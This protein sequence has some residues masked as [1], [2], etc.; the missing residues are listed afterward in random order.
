MKKR[1]LTLIIIVFAITLALMFLPIVSA[2]IFFSELNSKY[3]LGDVVEL[4]VK[5]DPIIKDRLLKIILF[6]NGVDIIEFNNLPDEQGNVNV[7]LP[8]NY[9]TIRDANGNCFFFGDYAGESRK[10]IEFEIS[11]LLIVKLATE[12][13]FANPEDEIVVSG[14]AEKLNGVSVD[15]EVEITIPLLNLLEVSEVEI[16]EETTTNATTNQSSENQSTQSSE[17]NSQT[18][19]TQT[20]Q[21]QTEQT[22]PTQFSTGKF[23][24]K[25]IDKQFSLTLKIPEN[26]PA[27][28]YRIDVLVYEQIDSYRTSEGVAIASLKV[29]QVLKNIE[30]ALNDF[31]FDPGTSIDIK[32]TLL[33]QTG[34]S[35]GGEI[36]VIIKDE[37]QKYF[38]KIGRSQENIQ[39][40][41]PTNLSSGY[42]NLIASSSGG[43]VN[44]TK[45]IFVNEK[46]IASFNLAN[47]TLIVKNIGNIPYRKDIQVELNAKSFIKRVS[48]E[49]G[50]SAKFKLTGADELYNV[51]ISDG[52]SELTMDSVRLT[53]RVINVAAV[54][55]PIFGLYN[56]IVWIFLIVVALIAILFLIR[57]VFKKK[58][59]A[60]HGGKEGVVELRP[61]QV[62][63]EEKAEM[64]E[65]K[66]TKELFKT[67]KELKTEKVIPFYGKA[68]SVL[69]LKGHKSQSAALVLK[70][71]NKIGRAGREILEKSMN[72]IYDNKGAVYEQANSIV[73]VFSPLM[74]GSNK[75]EAL[76]ARSAKNIF[77]ELNNYNKSAKEKIDFG[78]AINTGE[79]INKFENNKLKFTALGNFVIAGKRLADISNNQILLT[80]SAYERGISEIKANKKNVG[81]IEFYE[82]TDVV[83]TDKSKKFIKDFLERQKKENI[84]RTDDK[85]KKFIDDFMKRNRE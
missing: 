46:A 40:L 53:G 79:I 23:Y 71:K 55:E 64:Y 28:D 58:S 25:V 65:K 34:R 6:C 39:Y 2:G 45:K 3:N 1:S 4:N 44:S 82:I 30:L 10:S 26:A 41:I 63:F 67:E 38:E 62:E 37:N 73:A 47:E 54:G 76:A 14:T 33:D 19:E 21:T 51:K 15:G 17:N 50:E 8:L 24:G 9:H 72:Y 80:K 57:N 70:I 85:T 49:L 52:E 60:Y 74:T 11:K 31:N 75:N 13:F 36:S 43:E 5:A 27:G 59:F 69:V 42:Y 66:P 84:Q 35:I 7:K 68:D 18:Q 81:G 20:Q 77:N 83:D 56:P 22:T 48:L 61:K 78:I 32:T 29:F 16:T 12:A